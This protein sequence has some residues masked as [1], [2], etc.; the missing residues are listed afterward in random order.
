M[1]ARKAAGWVTEEDLAALAA[2]A[3]ADEAAEGEPA[4]AV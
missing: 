1:D 4:P 2:E 3:E